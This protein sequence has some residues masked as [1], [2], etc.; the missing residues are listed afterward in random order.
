MSSPADPKVRAYLKRQLARNPWEESERIV[1]ERARALRLRP[2]AAASAGVDTGEERQRLRSELD[3]L[4][5]TAFTA[6]LPELSERLARLKLDDYPD[7]RSAAERLRTILAS[8]SVLP[9]LTG[10][11]D[12][13]PDFL[14]CFK[15][16]LVSPARDTAVL[17]ERVLNS[18]GNRKLRKSGV[19][20]IRLLEKQA[21]AL[22]ALE[23]PWLD[24][25]T[26]QK[27]R[28]G[29]AAAAG[30]ASEKATPGWVVAVIVIFIVLPALRALSRF[31]D[32]EQPA[33][34]PP[35][36][37][38]TPPDVTFPRPDL[39]LS[40]NT[41]EQ[42][43]LVSW[44]STDALFGAQTYQFSFQPTPSNR[45]TGEYDP[46]QQPE[47]IAFYMAPPAID[48]EIQRLIADY[49]YPLPTMPGFN[50]ADRREIARLRFYYG[51]KKLHDQY[52]AEAQK[53][54]ETAANDPPPQPAATPLDDE[55]SGSPWD[56]MATAGEESFSDRLGRGRFPRPRYATPPPPPRG[57]PF[58]VDHGSP[59]TVGG[60]R[61][62]KIT[63]S[64]A[65][66]GE[67][68]IS[69]GEKDGVR[70]WKFRFKPTPDG[71][72]TEDQEPLHETVLLE[73]EAPGPVIAQALDNIADELAGQQLRRPPSLREDSNESWG[74]I[75]KR[76]SIPTEA[77]RLRHVQ[78]L[79]LL[80]AQHRQ[81]A[82]KPDEAEASSPWDSE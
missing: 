79:S 61:N 55:A 20:M 26:K 21:P 25:L 81:D 3:A 80:H 5:T 8:R 48:E 1:A 74:R 27:H 44:F 34:K 13:N 77:Q 73:F 67:I 19:R 50:R 36:V 70:V 64:S 9:Q 78:Q 2:R 11:R 22:C 56:G 75:S 72:D 33:R 31:G 53:R 37:T 17:R 69:L 35:T 12:F 10:H 16:V 38:V 66:T 30:S 4:R 49:K 23:R 40:P 15:E 71:V 60:R 52:I 63:R 82:P 43:E 54:V 47:V 59:W 46:L 14:A 41:A 6:P 18:F 28:S 7:L 65:T 76:L 29:G 32:E 58:R 45:R 24:A 51:L 42:T 62:A 57:S 39:R 68:R